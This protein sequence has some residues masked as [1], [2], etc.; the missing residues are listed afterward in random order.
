MLL[1]Y[2][3]SNKYA[4]QMPYICHIPKLFNVHQWGKYA[5][6][7][8]T[9]KLNDINHMMS[10]AVHR[11]QWCL[12]WQ[13]WWCTLTALSG[14]WSLTNSTKSTGLYDNLQTHTDNNLQFCRLLVAKQNDPIILKQSFQGH[15]T[16]QSKNWHKSVLLRALYPPNV[17]IIQSQ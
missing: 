9:Y 1:P 17:K 15:N 14:G 2:S 11:I 8:A 16:L 10:S 3:T 4:P 13:W 5:N 12:C 6:K 7:Y